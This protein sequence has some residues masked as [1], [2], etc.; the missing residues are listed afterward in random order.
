M[1]SFKHFLNS[2]EDSSESVNSPELQTGLTRN[3]LGIIAS[4]TPSLSLSVSLLPNFPSL[5][6]KNT[7]E[8]KAKFSE[9]V[10]K[11]V[12]SDEFISS[13]SDN[14]G[15]PKITETEEDFVERASYLLRTILEEKFKI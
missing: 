6:F 8:E 9:G 3:I 12:T 14:L 4:A 10:A 1:S 2:P 13:L 7:E 5:F 15:E 11:Y